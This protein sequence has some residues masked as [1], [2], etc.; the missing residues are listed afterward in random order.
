M[1]KEWTE[2]HPPRN[3]QRHNMEGNKEG[4]GTTFE[5]ARGSVIRRRQTSRWCNVDT[6]GPQQTA[7]L[8]CNGPRYIHTVPPD[9]TSLQAGAAAAKATTARKTNYTDITNTNIF[10]PV[11]IE[12]GV[13][14][15]PK[16]PN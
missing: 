16:P 10:I 11:A 8:G 6:L 3:A 5:G 7:G 2:T 14:G 9:S 15:V 4:S 13:H 12:M 1:Q